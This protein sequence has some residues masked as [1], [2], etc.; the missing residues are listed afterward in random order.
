MNIP[1]LGRALPDPAYS[2]KKT[3]LESY[4][5]HHQ[6]SEVRVEAGRN[7]ILYYV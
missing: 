2:D 3:S 7:Q 6:A 1:I 4:N 5:S